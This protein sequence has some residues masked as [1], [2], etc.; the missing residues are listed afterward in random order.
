[1]SADN[2]AASLAHVIASEGGYVCDPKDNGGATNQGITQA[3]YDLWRVDHGQAKRSVRLLDPNETEAIYRK[4][5]WDACR[6]DDLP[7]GVDYV[8]FDYAVNSGPV[9][10]CKSLQQAVGVPADGQIGP[11]TLAAVAKADPRRI[12]NA[13]CAERE[14]FLERLPTY[15]HFGRG[16]SHRVASVEMTARGM[17]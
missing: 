11:V 1:M 17:A 16:W 9:R 13:V 5:Y 10:A 14:A 8:V 3:V 12:I 6:C 2:F 4:R 15:S 7:A